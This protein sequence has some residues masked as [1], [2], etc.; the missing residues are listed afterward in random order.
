M[1]SRGVRLLGRGDE[2]LL[3]RFLAKHAAS[4]MFLR[5]NVRAAGLVDHGERLEGTYAASIDRGEIVAVAAHAWNGLVLVQAPDR[6]LDDVVRLATTRSR[7]AVRGLVGPWGQVVAA[8]AALSLRDRAATLESRED[9]FSL[10]LDA[11]A[12]PEILA[13]ARV[14]AR[15]ANAADLALLTDWRHD[16]MVEALRVEPGEGLHAASHDEIRRMI[17]EGSGFVL[18][19]DG[20]RSAFSGF[21]ARLPDVVQVGGVYTPPERRGRGYARA[22]VAA[23]LLEARRNGVSRALLFTDRLN[24]AARRAYVALGFEPIGDY[25]L[26]MF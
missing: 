10:A 3:E 13:S 15:R 12:V 26:L 7:R 14:V 19:A 20:E 16:Y 22:I 24:I 8:R 23:S 18:E 25:G 9:L 11:L 2:A 5:A 21:N 1:Q 4:S 17:E 6:D